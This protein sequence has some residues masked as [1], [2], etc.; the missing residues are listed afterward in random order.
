MFIS[1]LALMFFMGI[2]AFEVWP[3][4]VMVTCFFIG[5]LLSLQF[6]VYGVHWTGRMVVEGSRVVHRTVLARRPQS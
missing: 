2:V 3:M 5:V 4:G 6:L 1:A